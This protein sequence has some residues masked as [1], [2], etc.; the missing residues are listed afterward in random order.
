MNITEATKVR[1]LR[2]VKKGAI[3]PLQANGIYNWKSGVKW[4]K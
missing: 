1:F 4:V 3:D 2:G